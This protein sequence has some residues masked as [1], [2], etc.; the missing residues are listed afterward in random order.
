VSY[1]SDRH[2]VELTDQSRVD[3]GCAA[4][5]IF[6]AKRLIEEYGLQNDPEETVQGSSDDGNLGSDG[7]R[8]ES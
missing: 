6:D 1:I 7:S 4:G 2:P 3:L 5:K 8:R